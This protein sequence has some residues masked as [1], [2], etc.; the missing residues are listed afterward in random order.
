MSA[1][2]FPDSP[3]VGEIYGSAGVVWRWDG[4]RWASTAGASGPR[5]ALG[6]AT[7]TTNVAVAVGGVDLLQV[8]FTIIPGRTYKVTG[9]V[10]ASSTVSGDLAGLSVVDGGGAQQ[11]SSQETMT[12]AGHVYKLHL[13]WVFK[14]LVATNYLVK[15]R[16]SLSA[17]T[18][19]MSISAGTA[20][21]GFLLVEDITYEAGSSAPS[22]TPGAWVPLTFENGW[23]DF[24][25]PGS[26]PT[27]AVRKEGDVVRF[28]GLIKGTA[29]S[30]VAFTLP[31]EYRPLG[32]K[33]LSTMAPQVPPTGVIMGIAADNGGVIIHCE[34][35]AANGVTLDGVTFAP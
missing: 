1:L 2:D 17:G 35:P 32:Y 4:A 34:G 13:E 23:S 10:Y 31:V 14:G 21:P 7:L 18:G 9:H 6:F 20:Y 8:P 12:I 26:Y 19:S 30:T 27:P 24:G 16:G 25:S 29:G 5:G 33:H 22:S 28:Q 15:L 3:A 11:Q